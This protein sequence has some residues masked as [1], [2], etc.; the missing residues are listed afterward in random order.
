M[1]NIA[2]E[3]TESKDTAPAFFVGV[4]FNGSEDDLKGTL[5]S[6]LK[7]NSFSRS[8]HIFYPVQKHIVPIEQDNITCT[9]Y[10]SKDDF[11][12][13]LAD[14][15]EGTEADYC[16]VLWSGEEFFESAF[17]SV[18]RIFTQ[19][20]NINW[21]TGIQALRSPAGFNISLG[22]TAM[23]RWSYKIY[24]HNLYKNSGRFIPPASTFWRKD[25]WKQV[26]PWLH[27]V[28][29]NDFCEDLWVALFK[30][31]QLYTCKV[32][33]STSANDT[34]LYKPG[35]KRPNSPALIEDRAL[36]RVKEF[37]FINNIPYLRFLYR[38]EGEFAPVVRFD[39][40]TQS[41]FLSQY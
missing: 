28:E 23:R 41:Y 30:T 8:I 17:D 22:S 13:K 4:V 32:Y 16:T 9:S 6:V 3:N 18:N 35:I 24:E 29:Q 38:A 1:V 25:I 15:I 20:S 14:A 40:N 36:E 39:H 12:R 10:N 26:S 5:K 2:G 21:L 37:F 33:F 19:Y 7:Q 34:K 31:Q 11:F 27:F